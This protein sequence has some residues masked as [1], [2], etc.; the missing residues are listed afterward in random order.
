M[1]RRVAVSEAE[2]AARP[3]VV[4]EFHMRASAGIWFLRFSLDPQRTLLA[5]GNTRGETTIWQARRTVR[6]R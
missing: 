5:L 2:S 4:S 1:A 3:T 6:R